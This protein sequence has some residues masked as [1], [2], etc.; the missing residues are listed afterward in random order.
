MFQRF[1]SLENFGEKELEK[2]QSSKVAVVGLGATGSVIA[3]HLA[4]HGLQLL[5]VDRDY[6]EQKDLYTS[7]IY[8]KKQVER[9][10]PKAVAAEQKLEELTG[11]RAEVESLKPENIDIL[12]DVD[13]MMDGTDNLD[14]RFLLNDF[15]NE[16]AT[17]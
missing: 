8:S 3:E 11:V 1:K 5:L 9:G 17:P 6:L 10:L 16:T 2:L 15:L 4:R 12:K 7:N 13:L 14:T